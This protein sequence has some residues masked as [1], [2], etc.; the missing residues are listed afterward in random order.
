MISSPFVCTARIKFQ[1]EEKN[2]IM[3][4]LKLTGQI[5]FNYLLF[6]AVLFCASQIVSAQININGISI[7]KI[8][9]QKKGTKTSNEI[10]TAETSGKTETG[11][12]Q[13]VQTNPEAPPNYNANLNAGDK[14]VAIDSS[15]DAEAVK[16]LA[17]SGTA[18]KVAKLSEPDSVQWYSLNSVYPFYDKQG[19]DETMFDYKSYVAPYL[20]CYAKKH[21][22]EEGKVKGIG[23]FGQLNFSDANEARQSLQINQPK[24]AELDSL[25]KRKFSNTPNIFLDYNENPAIAAEIASQ[26]D[27]YL[28]CV[29]E[30]IENKPDIRL[31]IFLDDISKAKSEVDRYT[32]ADFLYLVSA[33]G[34]SEAL[35]RAVSPKAREE[36]SKQWLKNADSRAEFNTAWDEL[37]AAAAKKLP[38]YKPSPKSFQFK[39][40]AGEKLLMDYFKNTATLKIFRI[41]T[42]TA[43][44]D[45]QKDNN[46]FLPTYRYKSMRV[47]LR[48]TS[49]DH[50][51]CHVISARVKQDYAGGGAYNQSIYR[52]SVNDEII[53]C[54]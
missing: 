14:A 45:I 21:N 30:S 24:L 46:D 40:P 49:D 6:A 31:S 51:Y 33:G 42:D 7:P 12:Q 19:F 1:R 26:R 52:S 10:D 25:I 39:Y 11:A 3:F 35:L 41:G 34:N 13:D 38:L 4:N 50:P 16:I 17:K 47:Y 27:E 28:K 8:N 43:G 20:P 37:A 15:R 2:N 44:W 29:V 54:P 53:G 23:F 32:P 22:L 48:D 5:R 36:W 9:R 18:Y